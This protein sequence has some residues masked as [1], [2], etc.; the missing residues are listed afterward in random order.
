MPLLNEGKGAMPWTFDC[1]TLS[2]AVV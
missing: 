1:G 2:F